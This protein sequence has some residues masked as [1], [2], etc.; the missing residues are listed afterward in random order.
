MN[1][2]EFDGMKVVQMTAILDAAIVQSRC[3]SFNA[4]TGS[5]NMHEVHL[6]LYKECL[7][8][9]VSASGL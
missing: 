1:R 9:P 3:S 5:E 6:S 7:Y 8:A 2:V 4:L